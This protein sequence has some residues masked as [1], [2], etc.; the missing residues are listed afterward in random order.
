MSTFYAYEFLN[1]AILKQVGAHLLHHNRPDKT[2]RLH[3]PYA[4]ISI[5]ATGIKD[6]FSRHKRK[7]SAVS[8]FNGT[9][10][11][12]SCGGTSP[13]LCPRCHVSI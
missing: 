3:V 1:L 6:V 5:L 11:L 2:I 4:Y 10:E 12:Q 9:K 7:N 8:A 13:D